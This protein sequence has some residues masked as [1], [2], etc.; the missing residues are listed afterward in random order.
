MG[1]FDE[2]VP[3]ANVNFLNRAKNGHI[4]FCFMVVMLKSFSF[5]FNKNVNFL[6]P[7]IF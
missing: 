4:F 1:H 2:N 6:S 5:I 3:H 7:I